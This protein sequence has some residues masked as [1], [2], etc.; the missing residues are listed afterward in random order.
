[1]NTTLVAGDMSIDRFILVLRTRLKLVV[2]IF[3]TSVALSVLIT[4]VTPETYIANTSLNFEFK[5]ANPLDIQGRSLES[6]EYLATQMDI[7]RS[8][9][10]AQRVEDKLTDYE[11]DR[12]IE[13]IKNEKTVLEIVIRG[14]KDF[15]SWIGGLEEEGSNQ[16]TSSEDS[17]SV[18]TEFLVEDFESQNIGVTSA[19]SWMTRVV[20]RNLSVEPRIESRIVDVLYSSTDP[21]IAALMANSFAEAYLATNLDMTIDPARKT[22]VWFDAQLKD[23][24]QKLEA[25]QS[26]LT[27]YQQKEGI[28]SSDERMDTEGSRLQK[29]SGQLVNAQQDTRTAV[30]AEKKLQEILAKGV[31]LTTFSLVFD[32]AVVKKIK[33]EIRGKEAKL[34]D[35]SASLGRNHPRH[36]KLTAELGAARKRLEAEIVIITDGIINNAALAK[37][38]EEDLAG[39]LKDQKVLVLDLKNEHNRIAVLNREVESAN[40]TYNAALTQL[41]TTNMQSLVDQTNVTI[42]DPANIPGSPSSPILTKNI[43][44]GALAGLLLGVGMAILL[45]MLVRRVHNREDLAVELRLPVLGHLKK[46]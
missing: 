2:S 43:A 30:F 7:M 34:V 22:S 31:S 10:V 5:N 14:V 11:F 23:L 20:G 33:D 44:I 38:R 12:F 37:E 19:Y 15:F 8:Q 3:I 4:S 28:V 6:S 18:D 45:E 35:L 39:A 26:S 32:N 42:I 41:N 36:K 9:N 24:R 46:T 21:Q 40:K 16:S 29:L 17:V 27:E 25:A 13:A 1:M